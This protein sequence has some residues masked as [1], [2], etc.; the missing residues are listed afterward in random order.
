MGNNG[1]FPQK[2]TCKGLV[3]IIYS[4]VNNRTPIGENSFFTRF[5]QVKKKYT[6]HSE[7]HGLRISEHNIE[8]YKNDSINGS[9]SENT[10]HALNATF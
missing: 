6:N 9:C 5:P 2:V 4:H 1:Y 7:Y 8:K 3:F 10:K